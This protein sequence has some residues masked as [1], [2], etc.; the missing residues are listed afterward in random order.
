MFG[1]VTSGE[2][3]ELDHV[4]VKLRQRPQVLVLAITRKW[5]D[6]LVAV[7]EVGQ[8]NISTCSEKQKELSLARHSRR[9]GAGRGVCFFVH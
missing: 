8:Q 2:M 4:F 1:G 3:D 9:G 6:A 7:V 5:I